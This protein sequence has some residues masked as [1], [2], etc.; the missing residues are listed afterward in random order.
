MERPSSGSPL[1]GFLLG[2]AAGAISVS[3]VVT[4]VGTKILSSAPKNTY[5]TATLEDAERQEAVVKD[6]YADIQR[7]LSEL[8]Y[9]NKMLKADKDE[10]RSG[11]GLDTRAA[12]YNTENEPNW[13]TRDFSW[14][15][16]V[17]FQWYQVSISIDQN[18]YDY[19]AG[20]DRYVFIE[21][22]GDTGV[23][24]YIHDDVNLETV[25][26]FLDQFRLLQKTNNWSDGRMVREV[27]AC[28]Q[29]MPY[30]LDADSV[31]QEEYPRYPIET[32]YDGMGDCEDSS[33][34]LAACLYRLGYDCCFVRFPEHLGVG[35]RLDY[36]ATGT[37]F[38]NNGVHYYYI[39]TTNWGYDIGVMP[40]DITTSQ[41]YITLV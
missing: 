5:P 16:F 32:L 33:F 4:G 39:E 29:T 7:H 37:Y 28:I 22:G 3:A 26:M 6:E 17:D 19:Y 1:K 21:G 31:G 18:A 10:H 25:D 23:L 2:F 35:I 41:A 8:E 11:Y 9:E 20:L 36:E 40:D 27:I 38:D 13:Q 12:N 15:S 34:L 14:Q 24:S 30:I